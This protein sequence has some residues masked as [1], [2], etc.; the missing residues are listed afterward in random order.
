MS[1]NPFVWDKKH[2]K[3]VSTKIVSLDLFCDR[4]KLMIQNE[5]NTIFVNIPNK[6]QEDRLQVMHLYTPQRRYY[7]RYDLSIDEFYVLQFSDVHPGVNIEV[8]LTLY[9]ASNP[10]LKVSLD[11]LYEI[12]FHENASMN[13]GQMEN[14][15]H[16]KS[17]GNR[18]ITIKKLTGKRNQE[19]AKHQ[20]KIQRYVCSIPHLKRQS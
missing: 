10:I 7:N 11:S 16:L 17:I 18:T 14:I 8:N 1:D 12:V 5:R 15:V 2:S 19:I 9:N 13:F 3:E 20:T 6:E 4:S